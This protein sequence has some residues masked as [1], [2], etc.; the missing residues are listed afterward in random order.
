MALRLGGNDL[1]T[2]C[3]IQKHEKFVAPADGHNTD[4]EFTPSAHGTNG[5]LSVSLPGHPTPLD[6][7]VMATTEEFRDV[8][9]FNP[10]GNSGDVLGISMSSNY[11]QDM[12]LNYHHRL[13]TVYHWGRYEE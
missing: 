6:D 8:F 10:D 5:L 1:L 11:K 7:K 4:G 2:F 9:P 3:F 12:S 13:D